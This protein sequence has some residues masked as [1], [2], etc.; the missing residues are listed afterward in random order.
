MS[1]KR[2]LALALALAL[3]LGVGLSAGLVVSGTA[4]AAV[5]LRV[6]TWGGVAEQNTYNQIV[7]KFEAKNPDIKVKVEVLPWPEY[8][9]R[10]TVQLVGGIAPDVMRMSGAFFGR[11][12]RD[13]VLLNL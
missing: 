6:T 4:K 1:S 11:L 5:T 12:V 7:K 10:L 3:A 13:G 2:W 8:W 9:S